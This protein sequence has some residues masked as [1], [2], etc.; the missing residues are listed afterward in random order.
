MTTMTS[1][2]QTNTYD[3]LVHP[4]PEARP[5]DLMVVVFAIPTD[6]DDEDADQDAPVL[7]HIDVRHE[8]YDGE[9]PPY[10]LDIRSFGDRGLIRP[11]DV[12]KVYGAKLAR[13]IL[14][15]LFQ[16]V[17][18]DVKGKDMD[19]VPFRAASLEPLQMRDRIQ[20]LI[21]DLMR[22]LD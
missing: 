22:R 12:E 18:N 16:A 7:A 1:A 19:G 17:E 10:L 13:I 5:G 4:D 15:A 20:P 21:M 9:I 6:P 11:E 8:E 14:V 2:W 3:L